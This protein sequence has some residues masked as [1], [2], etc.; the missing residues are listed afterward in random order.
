MAQSQDILVRSL[1]TPAIL[2]RRVNKVE[3]PTQHIVGHFVDEF[4]RLSSPTNSV[5]ALKHKR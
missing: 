4:Y 1:L 3:L 5:K 2:Q